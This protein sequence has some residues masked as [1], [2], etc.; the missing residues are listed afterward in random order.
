[1]RLQLCKINQKEILKLVDNKFI[2]KFSKI[3]FTMAVGR[4]AVIKPHK[5]E[6]SK[7]EIVN[8]LELN[9]ST[10]WKIVYKL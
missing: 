8:L 6:K 2:P 9:R 4:N 1:M 3:S 10:M 5:S 7:V